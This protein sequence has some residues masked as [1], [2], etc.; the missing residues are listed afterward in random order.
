MHFAIYIV[1]FLSWF[2]LCSKKYQ[3]STWLQWCGLGWLLDDCKSTT[4]F[5]IFLGSHLISWASKTQWAVTR[6]STEVEYWALA[7][8]A[9]ELTWL[10]FLL[11]EI[12]CFDTTAPILW[13]DNLSAT[14]LTTNP[15]FPLAPNIWR[16]NFILSMK[17]WW[18]NHWLFVILVL[19]TR[20]SMFPRKLFQKYD[21]NI[22]GTSWLY[23]LPQFNLQASVTD[24]LLRSK[25]CKG[26]VSCDV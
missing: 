2:I 20:L 19:M 5:A 8:T 7:T 10:E 26:C 14:Y 6:S 24:R 12:G 11:R 21:F 4:G 17:R 15:I 1:H 18:I 25:L 13:C 23:M 22:S 9:S 3:T 16:E